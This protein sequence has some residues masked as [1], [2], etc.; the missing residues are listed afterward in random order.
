M[1]N[2]LESRPTF[3][4]YVPQW[5]SPHQEL[6]VSSANGE[7]RGMIEHSNGRYVAANHRGTTVGEFTTLA[8]AQ[9]AVDGW[10]PKNADAREVIILKAIAATALLCSTVMGISLIL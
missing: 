2:V 3:S 5:R 7:Y 10:S 9:R 4:S 8:Q 6:W 1:T